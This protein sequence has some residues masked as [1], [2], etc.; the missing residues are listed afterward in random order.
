MAWYCYY[1]PNF[2]GTGSPRQAS[3]EVGYQYRFI[4]SIGHYHHKHILELN[5][6]YIKNPAETY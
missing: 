1:L 4:I 5:K 3:G 6:L 2:I